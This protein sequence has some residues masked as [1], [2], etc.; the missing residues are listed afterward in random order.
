MLVTTTY[1]TTAAV[2]TTLAEHAVKTFGQ[3]YLTDSEF[4]VCRCKYDGPCSCGAMYENI[5]WMDDGVQ[6][7]WDHY[8]AIVGIEFPTPDT[9]FIYGI[10]CSGTRQAVSV[11]IASGAISAAHR[12][13]RSSVMGSISMLL[14]DEFFKINQAED[15]ELIELQ[16]SQPEW[17]V[18]HTL[19]KGQLKE[20]P[21]TLEEVL[22]SVDMPTV[23]GDVVTAKQLKKWWDSLDGFAREKASCEA[24]GFLDQIRHRP[25]L[26]WNVCGPQTDPVAQAEI[27]WS[28]LE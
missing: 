28:R 11:N 27:I 13:A 8:G 14:A 18:R 16:T 23:P 9:I 19:L 2:A 22:D 15:W 21:C 5:R 3:L 6:V 7:Q 24:T 12:G 17:G 4:G 20:G 25:K 10:T 26:C 1:K